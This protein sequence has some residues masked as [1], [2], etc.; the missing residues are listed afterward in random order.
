MRLRRIGSTFDAEI[1][2]CYDWVGHYGCFGDLL[3]LSKLPGYRW[4]FG[5]VIAE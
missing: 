1:M 4:R 2:Y 3:L 5:T